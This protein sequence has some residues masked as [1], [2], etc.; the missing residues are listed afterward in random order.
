MRFKIITKNYPF[1][2]DKIKSKTYLKI[3]RHCSLHMNVLNIICS[4]FHHSYFDIKR[5]V[6]VKKNKSEK[7]SFPPAHYSL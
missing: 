6:L 3:L 5:D 1:F 7:I 4:K 2:L